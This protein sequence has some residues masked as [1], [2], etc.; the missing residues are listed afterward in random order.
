MRSIGFVMAESSVQDVVNQTLSVGGLS[1]SDV[2]ATTSNNKSTGGEV[3]DEHEDPNGLRIETLTPISR[4]DE[5][6]LEDGSVRSDTDGSRADGSIAG[7]KSADQQ[8]P[9]KKFSISK[10]VSFAKYSVPK[11]IAA[12]TATKVTNDK[13]EFEF[14]LASLLFLMV[15][16]VVLIV[17]DIGPLSLFPVTITLQTRCQM[18]AIL[19]LQFLV[20]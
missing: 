6:T 16:T 10:P 15:S 7:D 11:V 3:G 13:G 19:L 4:N 20:G 1:P 8:K 18:Y 2:T 9:P 14:V 17:I 12:T 5:A